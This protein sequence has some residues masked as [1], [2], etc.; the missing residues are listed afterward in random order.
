MPKI[1]VPWSLGT[2]L[3]VIAEYCDAPRFRVETAQNWSYRIDGN[4]DIYVI[5][6]DGSEFIPF[7]TVFANKAIA[8]STA[9]GKN[10]FGGKY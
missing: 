2:K 6:E 1:E 8:K 3:Y 5:D 4:G 7:D 9:I 10:T